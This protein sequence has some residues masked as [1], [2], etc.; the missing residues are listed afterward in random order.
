[1]SYLVEVGHSLATNLIVVNSYNVTQYLLIR[2]KFWQIHIKLNFLLI[3][4]ILAQILKKKKNQSPIA[5]FYQI[6]KF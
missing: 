2:Y 4:F 3:F 5:M 6:F 1:M